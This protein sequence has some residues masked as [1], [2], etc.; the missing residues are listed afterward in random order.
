MRTRSDESLCKGAAL[1]PLMNEP[2]TDPRSH[3]AN[4]KDVWYTLK[5]NK[6]P[7]RS[8]SSHRNSFGAS[9]L[10]CSLSKATQHPLGR[11][12]EEPGIPHRSSAFPGTAENALTYYLSPNAS[13]RVAQSG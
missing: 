1:Q 11:F 6:S 7:H 9:L 5:K 2:G 12:A 8:L 4:R 13:I 3:W 10:L